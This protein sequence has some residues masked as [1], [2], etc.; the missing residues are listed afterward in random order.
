[1]AGGTWKAQDKRRPGAYI[2][3]VGRSEEHTSEL[4]SPS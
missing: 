1:M 3:V 2:N 4:Q